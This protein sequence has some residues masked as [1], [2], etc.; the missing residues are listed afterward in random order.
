MKDGF[1]TKLDMKNL[2][3]D[4]VIPGKEKDV[5]YR[6]SIDAAHFQSD[7]N[8][9]GVVCLRK[10]EMQHEYATYE[11][12]RFGGNKTIIIPASQNRIWTFNAGNVQS[13]SA[14]Y[15]CLVREG[16]MQNDLKDRESYR[17]KINIDAANAG[18]NLSVELFELVFGPLE[19]KLLDIYTKVLTK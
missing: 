12:K 4:F 10:L 13:F 1:E 15:I 18:V 14:E 16:I 5:L 19:A 17:S 8:I 7:C 9:Y 6:G 3:N 11:K 2:C